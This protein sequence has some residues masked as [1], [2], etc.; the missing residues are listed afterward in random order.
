MSDRWRGWGALGGGA[1][2]VLGAGLPWV[3]FFG[4]G[5][6]YAG[7][8]GG[9]A[10][11]VLLGGLLLVGAGALLLA[12]RWGTARVREAGGALALLVLIFSAHLLLRLRETVSDMR[13]AGPALAPEMGPGLP[14]C[15]LG[16][17]VAAAALLLPGGHSDGAA[18]SGTPEETPTARPPD[19][20]V[21]GTSYRSVPVT[22]ESPP[23][24]RSRTDIRDG[25]RP[26]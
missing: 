7:F 22:R 11:I 25:S 10:G 21:P 26:S 13:D 5:Y 4:D 3:T 12:G 18:R 17:L 2:V 15:V 23:V 24:R 6:R 8:Q 19:R 16:G 1:L 20:S 9:Q 14:L